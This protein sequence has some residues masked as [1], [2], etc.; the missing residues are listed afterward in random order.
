MK[1]IFVLLLI[2]FP[3]VSFAQ[4]ERMDY[5]KQ[6]LS[7]AKEDTNKV[8][9]LE[10]LAT[11]YAYSFA[12]TGVTYAQQGIQLAQRLKYKKGEAW[13]MIALCDALTN[14]GS[15]GAALNWGYKSLSL[16]KSL[17]DTIG[18]IKA[19]GSL[20]NCYK[21]QDDYS[22]SLL[23]FKAAQQL[24]SLAKSNSQKAK[25]SD[26]SAIGHSGI[27]KTNFKKVAALFNIMIASV[28]EK[29][30]ELDSALF[31]GEQGYKI[32]ND[33]SALYETGT[34]TVYMSI[35][36]ALYAKLGN[37]SLAMDFYKQAVPLALKYNDLECYNGIARVYLKEGK[38]DSA[39]YYAKQVIA[40][41]YSKAYPLA[42]MNASN[43]LAQ[44]YES[45]NKTDSTLKYLKLTVALKDSLFNQQKTREAQRVAFNEQMYQQELS[46]QK[47]ELLYKQQLQNEGLIRKLLVGGVLVLSLLSF[48]IIR[49]IALKRKMLENKMLL[50]QKEAEHV[51]ALDKMKDKFFSNITHEFRTPLS[52]ILSPVELYLNNPNE[53]KD[54]PKFLKTIHQNANY[55]LTL[56]NQLLDLAKLEAGN[57]KVSLSKADFGCYT[58]ELTK[59]FAENIKQKQLNLSFEN[60]IT[61]EY[62][63]D[64]EHWKKI[65]NNLLSNAIKFTPAKGEI[66]VST[67]KIETLAESDTIR[68]EVRDTGI[69]I[70]KEQIPFVT[71]RFYQADNTSTRKFGGTGIGLALVH[72][73]VTLMN[74]KLEIISEEEKGSAFIITMTLLHAEGKTEYSE[75]SPVTSASTLKFLPAKFSNKYIAANQNGKASQNGNAPLILVVEDNVE[76]KEFLIECLQHDYRV[77]AASDGEEAFQISLRELPDIII[78]DVMMPVMDGFEF[79][80]KIKTHPATS[81][82]AF[83]ILSAKTAFDSKITGLKKGADVYL[84]K[85][86]SVDELRLRIKNMLHRQ[87]KLRDFYLQQ[88]QPGQSLPALKE[89]KDEFLQS[90][91]KIMEDN[92]DSSLL[93]V[94]FLCEQIGV[95]KSTLNR[96]L[97]AIIGLSANELIKQYR[98]KKAAQFLMSGKNVSETA[99]SAG[100]E[101]PSYFIHCFREFYKVT[102]KEYAK[103]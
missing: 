86:F 50:E 56:I 5:L 63:F 57:M 52:L 42:V 39:V 12:D 75:T 88:L 83:I 58:H 60:N 74:G 32:Q 18:M 66:Y 96:K 45:Q 81:H 84:I 61:G 85:P 36:G 89:I 34:A 26:T 53:L 17:K 28:Y 77:I 54:T 62:L 24:A 37:D 80:D 78:S 43:L 48:I 11:N 41:P 44:V 102:P 1:K 98:L 101:T 3:S 72:E 64:T 6:K 100:F 22:Q 23:F 51:M 93:N 76:L 103:K 47:K 95:S 21:E 90:L 87:E 92:L 94:E 13:C 10:D 25:E 68:L 20:G 73:L 29:N 99:Y 9:I 7:T 30:N 15:Y 38:S 31:Y 65:V 71:N 91:Y 35:M 2:I 8:W 59:N 16:F 69:G 49:N 33:S 27:I 55:L 82:I 19:N 14:L 46:N 79:C 97:S 40:Q 70:S 4:T 67:N